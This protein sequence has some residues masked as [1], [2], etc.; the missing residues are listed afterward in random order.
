[1]DVKVLTTFTVSAFPPQAIFSQ[2]ADFCLALLKVSRICKNPNKAKVF[3]LAPEQAGITCKE[4][5]N[6]SKIFE[7]SKSKIISKP[8]L[9]NNFN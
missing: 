7:F 6:A 1:V 2:N 4:I 9:R 5:L 3:E 8:Y